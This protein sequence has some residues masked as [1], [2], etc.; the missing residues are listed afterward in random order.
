MGIGLG[1]LAVLALVTLLTGPGGGSH[2]LTSETDVD[3][4]ALLGQGVWVDLSYPASD[5]V[6]RVPADA[7]AGTLVC[8]LELDPVAPGDRFGRVARGEDA[9]EVRRIATVM[10]VTNGVLQ[11]N[12]PEGDT[13][14][15]VRVFRDEIAADGWEGSE[16]I[17]PWSWG[18]VY[19][20]A[21]DRVASLVEDHGVMLW[22][23]ATGVTRDNLE[24]FTRS[25]ARQ[26]RGTR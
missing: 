6:A 22:I 13:G 4:C 20:M 25:A 7:E 19:T 9:D 17:G 12:A 23:T 21:E 11:Q 8:A 24:R 3:L 1:V 5:P 26:V 15:Y 14:E 10:L 16:V 2:P 18:A